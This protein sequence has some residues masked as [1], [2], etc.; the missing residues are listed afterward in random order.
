VR[1][2]ALTAPHTSIHSPVM[3]NN[4]QSPKHGALGE[5]VQGPSPPLV[6]SKGQ[7]SQAGHDAQIQS[8][9]GKWLEGVFLPAGLCG[10]AGRGSARKIAIYDTTTG[11]TYQSLQVKLLYC[12]CKQRKRLQLYAPGMASRKSFKENGGGA[13][14]STRPCDGAYWSGEEGLGRS[15]PVSRKEWPT[16][17]TL[18]GDHWGSTLPRKGQGLLHTTCTCTW[19]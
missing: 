11:A 9:V 1:A 10:G 17:R 5:P 14:R 3:S 7:G 12:R 2:L 8:Q 18:A 13:L 16:A 19:E 6:D 15:R 4:E